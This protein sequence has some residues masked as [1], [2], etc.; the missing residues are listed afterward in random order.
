[1]KILQVVPYFYPAWAYGG[2]AKL[3]Y[4]TSK[5]FA[6]SGN[7]VIVY[8]SDSYDQNS[9]MPKNKYVTDI[10]NLN[11]RYFKNLN[12]HLAYVYNIFI[13]PGII[14]RSLTEFYKFDVIHI[15][16]FYTTQNIWI[17]LLA[18]LYHKPYILSVHGCL[19]E[20]RIAQRSLFKKLF[21]SF[22]GRNMLIK[23]SLVIATSPNEVTA[24]KEYEIPESRIVL[25]GHGVDLNEFVT[26]VTKL[27]ARKH[28]HLNQKDIVVTFLGRIHQIKGLDNLVKAI[29][30]VED[31]NIHF[32]IAGSND[33]Y[34]PTLKKDIKKYKLNNKITLVGTCFGEEK[35]QL[36]KASDIFVYP[37]YSE[38]FS[39]GILEAAA[40]G[41]PLIITTGCHFDEVGKQKAGII[42][43][44]D[45]KKIAD[46]IK[47]L[48]VDQELRQ[49][50]GQNAKQLI[51]T[52]YSM[53]AIGD[54]FINFYKKVL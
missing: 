26:K 52:Q 44:P 27:E 46:A 11:I 42:V 13:T 8:T 35:S 49:K 28:F 9:R 12:N 51:N 14:L 40:A 19:E 5:Y 32:V 20:K 53:K 54:K 15:H 16:D 2:P 3:V 36:F 22:F 43:T 30:M 39:L 4:D 31:K 1:M 48:C 21:L 25:C 23:A 10:P 41:L 7:E 47:K 38:G 24:Y 50:F 29:R 6:E 37:S 18:L 33:G 34:L 45:E 17:T